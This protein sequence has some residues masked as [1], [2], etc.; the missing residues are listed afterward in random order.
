M[1]LGVPPESISEIKLA[2]ALR[3]E[4]DSGEW[5]LSYFYTYPGYTR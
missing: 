5:L 4:Q 1:D 2:L 3:V